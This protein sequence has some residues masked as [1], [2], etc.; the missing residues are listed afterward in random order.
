LILISIFFDTIISVNSLLLVWNQKN[1]KAKQNVML[2]NFASF[3]QKEKKQTI[4]KGYSGS[5]IVCLANLRPQKDHLNLL[6]AFTRVSEVYSDWTLHLIGLDFLDDYSEKI[7]AYIKVHRLENHVFLYGSC[8]DTAHILEQATIGVL[9]SSSEGLPVALLEYG[10]MKLPV[11]V[12]NVGVC[13]S[14]V[15]N[16]NNGL[17]VSKENELEFT[18][19]LEN[20][21]RN[22][23][24]RI[25]FGTQLY[26]NINA[27]Y[28]KESYIK[29]LRCIYRDAN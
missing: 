21:I 4:L 29:N 11:V 3:N 10:L 28:S 23:S 18:S 16:E 7:K 9:A 1:L 17:L 24:K 5:R 14:V 2:Y 6:K 22:K 26:K 13:S 20:L 12:T 25:K 8:S 19:A 15:S 27:N